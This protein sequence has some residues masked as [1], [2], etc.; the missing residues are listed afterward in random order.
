MYLLQ[1]KDCSYAYSNNLN[2]DYHHSQPVTHVLLKQFYNVFVLHKKFIKGKL[3]KLKI[4]NIYTKQLGNVHKELN[5]NI[6]RLYHVVSCTC[7]VK[8]S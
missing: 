7:M 3:L 6:A 1:T 8:A 4:G 2:L 5:K